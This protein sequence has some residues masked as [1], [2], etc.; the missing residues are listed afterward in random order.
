[1]YE[2]QTAD[3]IEK[4]ML[5][6]VDAKYDKR[7]GSVIYDATAPASI[8]L[9]E[10][11]IMADTILKQ[12]FATTADRD[13]LI[14]RAAEFNIAP[15][16]ATYAIVKAQFNQAV[17]ISSRFNYDTLNFKVTALMSDTDHT[18]QMQCETAGTAGNSCIG[19]ITPIGN[20]SGLTSAAIIELITPAEDDEDTEAFRT[21]YFKALKSQA[22]GG[23]G[24]DYQEKV[25]A[26][27]GVGGAKVYRC[28]N[29]GGTVKCVVLDN[30]YSIPNADFL[31]TL[32]NAIDPTPQGKGYGIAPIG[33]TVT[34]AGA[35]STVI[36]IAATVSTKPGIVV[37]DVKA[38]M[39]TAINAYFTSLRKTWCGQADT[40]YVTVH[41]AYIQSAVLD[42]A[43]VTDIT[44][45][46]INGNTDK[47]DLT[48]DAVPTLGTLTPTQG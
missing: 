47:V 9:A 41:T 23:N 35:T 29:G 12:T 4:R 31:N 7:E 33:H 3:V 20:I 44:N 45:T 43:G 19:S 48:T 5:G 24:A 37:A 14:L 22:Y 25:L 28:W 32:Q 2:S 1:L 13:Y 27:A 16:A 36:N 18:Y 15:N 11:Y 6:N 21:R 40:D 8:E 17:S 30:D 38:A 26:I 46:T 34:V 39:Q 42:V 10:A